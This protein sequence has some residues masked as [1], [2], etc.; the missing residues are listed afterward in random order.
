MQHDH[1]KSDTPPTGTDSVREI[2]AAE[3]RAERAERAVPPLPD[4]ARI[5]IIR[6]SS[7]GDVV[8]CSALPRLIRSRFPRAHITM[9]TSG[10]FESLFTHNPHLDRTIGF[11]RRAGA[12]AF[13]ELVGR[14]RQEKFDLVADLHK[15][16]RSRLL[17]LFLR[18]PRTAYSKHSWRRFLLIAFRINTFADP[19]GKE[20]EFLAGLLPYGVADDGQ[21]TELHVGHLSEEG[22]FGGRMAAE[23][24]RV[25]EWRREGRPVLGVAPIAAWELKRWPLH[26]FRLLLTG[27]TRHT[28]GRVLLFGG[29]G[30][31]AVEE[32]IEGMGERALSLVGRTTQLES[33]YFASL[34]DLVVA[35]DTGMTHLAEAV[36]TDV[37]TLY[38]PTS[39][40]LGYYPVRPGSEV[41]ELPLPC[42]PCTP[43][44]KGKCSHPHYKAC[45]EGIP[46]EKAL[47]RVLL[48][49]GGWGKVSS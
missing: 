31:E 39:R 28:N 30:D 35:N 41:L 15:S 9:L 5:L 23:L 33:A 42:R 49:L 48:R 29:P 2:P 17:G 11:D 37:I 18:G 21:G 40:E 25:R 10:E 45:L 6:F 47:E 8:K 1:Q 38:G 19:R 34:T 27:Y 14:L 24:A 46:P 36:G 44:G 26:H 43:T 20:E 4:D 7:L 16:L 22:E 32:L 13:F 12:G 3:E